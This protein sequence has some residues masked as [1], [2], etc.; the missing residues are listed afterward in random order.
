ML[1]LVQRCAQHISIVITVNGSAVTNNDRLLCALS[2]KGGI[3][4]SHRNKLGLQLVSTNAILGQANW[5]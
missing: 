4:T 1:S 2:G 3:L 5:N